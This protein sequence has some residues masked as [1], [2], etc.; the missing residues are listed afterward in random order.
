VST[1]VTDAEQVDNLVRR[2]VD[3]YGGLHVAFN[4]AGVLP[5]TGP[6]LEQTEADWDKIINVDLKGVF[7]SLKAE[8]AQMVTR[9]GGSIINTASVAG[10]IA[11]P[12]MS[13]Y[14][15]AKHGVVGLTKAAALDYGAAGIR[16]NALAP[17]LVETPMTKGWLDDPVM[18]GVVTANTPLGRPAQ[19][20]EIAGMVLFLASPLASYANGGVYVVDGGQTAH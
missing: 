10:V 16:V 17:G 1:D 12:G 8:I 19:P 11:D 18:R 5:P 13:P 20:D 9:G 7:L 4:N 2:S 14:V 15:A 6:L 3:T